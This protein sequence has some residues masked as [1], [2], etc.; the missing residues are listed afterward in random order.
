M[1]DQPALLT[2]DEVDA[3]IRALPGWSG[4]TSG[5]ERTV[6]CPSFEAAIRLVDAIAVVAEGMDH[7][8]D[9]DIRWRN[10]RFA[11]STHSAG[12]LTSRDIALAKRIDALAAAIGA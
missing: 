2:A 12:G 11:V 9:M 8:P 1:A 10:V 7:H 6:E 5:I 4:D 3:A